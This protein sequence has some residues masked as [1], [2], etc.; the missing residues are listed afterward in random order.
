MSNLL[1]ITNIDESTV[2]QGYV[3]ISGTLSVA[4]TDYEQTYTSNN[5]DPSA[6]YADVKSQAE[7]ALN[8]ILA[9][10][11]ITPSTTI[12]SLV[13]DVINL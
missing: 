3:T 11:T 13:G 1:T 8:N 4:G 10:P 2:E 6:I 5:T 7:V 9:A 12:S